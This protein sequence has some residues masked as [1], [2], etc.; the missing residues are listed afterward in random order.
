MIFSGFDDMGQMWREDYET[1]DFIKEMDDL[2]DEVR[3]LYD[4]LHK[5]VLGKLAERYPG[6]VNASDK[7]IPAHILGEHF[8]NKNG[9]FDV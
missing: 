1:D 5:Y 2:W 9:K 8:S 7:Y 6:K 3:P 4:Q